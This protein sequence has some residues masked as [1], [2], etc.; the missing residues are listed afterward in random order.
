MFRGSHL[1]LSP[2]DFYL[3]GTNSRLFNIF[4]AAI[5]SQEA[6]DWTD[7]NMPLYSKNI[8]RKNKLEKHHIFPK[9]L[10]YEHYSSKNTI[11]KRLVNEIANMAFLTENSNKTIFNNEPIKYLPHID[12]AELRKQFIPLDEELWKLQNYEDFLSERRRL[13]SEGIN[14]C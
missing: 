13:L 1:E 3:Q 7:P 6:R 4:Y 11:D 2:E 12:K 14:N 9:S 8:G 10:L 5:R